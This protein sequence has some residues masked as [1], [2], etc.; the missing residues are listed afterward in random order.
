MEEIYLISV[1]KPNN[2]ENP[3]PTKLLEDYD[4][5]FKEPQ[6]LPPV[7]GVEHQIILKQDNNLKH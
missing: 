3:L 7:R 2:E 4:D 1:P 6:G 5:V